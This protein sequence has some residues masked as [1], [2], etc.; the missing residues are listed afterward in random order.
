MRRRR[1][2]YI[3]PV[4]ALW[5][6]DDFGS[7]QPAIAPTYGRT[8]G[9][10]WNRGPCAAER[11]VVHSVGRTRD[12][13]STDPCGGITPIVRAVPNES[14]ESNTEIRGIGAHLDLKF[15]GDQG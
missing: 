11:L 12:N 13:A 2:R 4:E 6:R 5:E 3:G 10:S 1:F 14:I 9:A 8:R 15:F 7:A